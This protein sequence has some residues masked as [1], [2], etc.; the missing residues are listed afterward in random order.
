MLKKNRCN[1]LQLTGLLL[2]VILGF[3]FTIS[4]QDERIQYPGILKNSYFGVNIGSINYPFTAAQ[5]NDGNTVETVKAPH[6][7]VRIILLGHQFF[8]NLSAGG[9]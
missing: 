6:T 9:M 3:N 4:A 8:K 5:L 2:S 1:T 7:A